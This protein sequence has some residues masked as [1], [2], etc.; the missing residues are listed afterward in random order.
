MSLKP[1]RCITVISSTKISLDMRSGRTYDYRT[2]YEKMVK[3]GLPGV[4]LGLPARKNR[5]IIIDVD[6][7]KPTRKNDGRLWVEKNKDTYPELMKTCRVESPSAG[8]HFYLRVPKHL[9]EK[10]FTPKRSL[11]PGVDIIW[12]GYCVCPPSPGYV[13][14]GQFKDIQL[15]SPELLELCTHKEK[16][17][18][19]DFSHDDFKINVPLA[20]NR[21]SEL[22]SKLKTIM[23][24]KELD[25]NKWVH[26]IFS[27]RSAVE[28]EGM[29][30]MCLEAWSLNKSFQEGDVET[31]IELS[32]ESNPHGGISAG[33]I[34]NYI[35]EWTRPKA[36]VVKD[37]ISIGDIFANPRLRIAV[38]GKKEII[39][40]SESNA[41]TIIETLIPNGYEEFQRLERGESLYMDDRKQAVIY[42][43][44]SI[45]GGIERM[46]DTLIRR[47]QGDLGLSHIK[48]THIRGGLNIMLGDRAVDPLLMWIKELKWD[49]TPRI[50]NFFIDYAT[51]GEDPRYLINVG[52]TFWRSLVYRIF[53]PGQKADEVI[54]LQG[55]E[56]LFKTSLVQLI[57]KNYFF[58]CGNRHAFLERDDLLNMHR[59][60]VVE[61]EELVPLLKCDPDS[62]KGFISRT[63]DVT[64]KMFGRHSED[65]PRSFL[66]VGT[67]NR[68]YFIAPQIGKRRF[69][70]VS[71]IDKHSIKLSAVL[72]DLDQ[73]YAE[74]AENWKDRLPN[75]GL[76][77]AKDKEHVIGGF[78]TNDSLDTVIDRVLHEV[79]SIQIHD[80]FIKLRMMGVLGS[81]SLNSK[82]NAHFTEHLHRRGWKLDGSTWV[83]NPEKKESWEEVL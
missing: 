29:R 52:R 31:A 73:F 47:I 24:D 23:P 72:A 43:G 44:T 67:T 30:K 13:L 66:L 61:L 21:V 57:A 51:C 80:L 68:K 19:K 46:Q 74:A 16:D 59:S 37:E 25:Y 50:D 6:T 14:L 2:M 82:I 42:N 10:L 53:N 22:L 55:D 63:T 64:R 81:A 54:V 3:G 28:D 75:Y 9:D 83:K 65:C 35:D 32:E 56:G 4:A 7:P 36:S 78:S 1:L 38:R 58:A 15:I 27:I 17:R 8:C 45:K 34:L 40:P 41:A 60:A 62:A 69:L 20:P 11:A 79:K 76:V 71:V 70:P 33:T 77:H 26:G 39:L 49:G 5:L 12:Q 18:S 48:P